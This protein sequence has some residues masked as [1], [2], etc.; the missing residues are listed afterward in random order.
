MKLYTGTGDDGSTGL[1]GS[2]RLGKDHPRVEAY[3]CV[4]ELN[5][6]IG[7]AAA[8]CVDACGSGGDLAR[9]GS[10]LGL[11]SARLFTV[12]ADLAT[13]AE[14]AHGSKITRTAARDVTEIEGWID[15]I[16]ADNRP[17]KNFVLPGGTELAARLH[18]ARTVARRAERR[19]VNL[20]R[21][22]TV[23]PEVVVYLNRVSD[24]LFAMAR[25]ANRIK[26]VQDVE[27]RG[28]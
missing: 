11:L 23:T 1:F 18:V 21:M 28:S 16:D 10:I 26:G 3:G 19:V 17:M 22:D 15:E 20:T 7:L 12:G 25:A 8:G 24:L 6:H 27:W 5:A 9:L 14:E 2:E 4:D 13:P